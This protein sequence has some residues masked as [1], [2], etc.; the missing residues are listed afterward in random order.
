MFARSGTPFSLLANSNNP[1]GTLNNRINNV[2]GTIQRTANGSQRFALTPGTTAA[3]IV[4]AA[5]QVGT[6]GRNSERAPSFVDVNV[7]LQKSFSLTERLRAQFRAEAFNALNR[8]NY[9]TPINNLGN[10]LFGR[11]LTAAEARQFQLMLKVSF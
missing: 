7:S 9:D 8:A 1:F 3:Q 6:L 4:P 10:A 2:P 5:G 11:V